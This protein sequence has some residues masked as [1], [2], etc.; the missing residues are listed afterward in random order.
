[1]C[2]YIYIYIYMGGAPR[3]PAPRNHFM[4]WI[5]KPSGCHCAD[6]HFTSIV[7]WGS[8]NIVA[9]RPPLGALALSLSLVHL[10]AVVVLHRLVGRQDLYEDSAI[11]S[12]TPSPPTKTLDF[13]GFDSSRLLILKG[14]N[15]HV[16]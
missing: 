11:I 8:T 5:V 14:G 15:S 4:V 3:N 2:V 1:M 7:H 6:G 9:C 12:T 10:A 16:R 13:G